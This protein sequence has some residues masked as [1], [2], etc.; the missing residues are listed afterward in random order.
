MEVEATTIM[1]DAGTERTDETEGFNNR[2]QSDNCARR[3]NKMS[4]VT[5][6]SEAT[7]A[8]GT[9]SERVRQWGSTRQ[10]R[11]TRQQ[12]SDAIAMSE[13]TEAISKE[14][15][16]VVSGSGYQSESVVLTTKRCRQ[17]KWINDP[18][19]LC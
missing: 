9:E 6:M 14:M 5:A 8:A 7:E 1:F 3:N 18:K 10:L 13:A 16:S 17:R 12:I 2:G 19:V 11:L 4:D 15:R